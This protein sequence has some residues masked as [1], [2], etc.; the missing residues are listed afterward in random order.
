MR[1]RSLDLLDTD[2]AWRRTLFAARQRALGVPDR[3]PFEVIERLKGNGLA[4]L[5]EEHHLER[6]VLVMA[7]KGTGTLRP[8]VRLAPVDLL[9]YQALVD[10]LAS[11][12]ETTLGPRD[13]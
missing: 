9:L 6:V 11:S 3:L 2:L 4:L 12:I 10:R 7:T 5:E 1:I 13:R 8:Y